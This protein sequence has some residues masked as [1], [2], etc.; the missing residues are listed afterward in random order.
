MRSL[1]RQRD[2]LTDLRLRELL[3]DHEFVSQRQR[4]DREVF[5]A[6]DRLEKLRMGRDGLQPFPDLIS[7]SNRAVDQFC[8]GDPEAKRLILEITGYNPVLKDKRLLIRAAKPF[9][10]WPK[11]PTCSAMRGYVNVTRTLIHSTNEDDVKRVEMIR[12]AV[13]MFSTN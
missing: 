8:R 6:K 1:T 9:R 13:S 7:F 5:S 4:L 2:S 11:T 10:R 3:T 12:E